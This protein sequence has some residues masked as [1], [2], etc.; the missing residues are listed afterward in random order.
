MDQQ[1]GSHDQPPPEEP[2]QSVPRGSDARGEAA[3]QQAPPPGGAACLRV[4]GLPEKGTLMVDAEGR[5]QYASP[6]AARQLG[7]R[8]GQV[9]GRRLEELFPPRA[10]PGGEALQASRAELSAIFRDAPVMM[11]LVDAQGRVL[12]SNRMALRF[13]RRRGREMAGLQPGEALR[14]LHA[15]DSP[16]GCGFGLFCGACALRASIAATLRTGKSHHRAE[17]CLPIGRRSDTREHHFLVSTVRL[18]SGGRPAVLVC[19][20]DVTA[21]RET[22]MALG[23]SQRVLS[24]LMSNL[25]GMAYRCRNDQSWTMEFI[26]GGCRE[27]TGYRPGDLVANRTVAFADLIHPDD[28]VPVWRRVQ[29]ALRERQPYELLYRIVA[30]SGEEK[31]VWEKGR[32][33]FS[34]EGDLRALE[35]F[36]TDITERKRAEQEREQMRDLLLH[37]QKME[38]VGVLAAGVAHDFN[39]LLTIIHGNAQ[40]ALNTAQEQG[41][42]ADDLVKKIL[43]A[44]EAG[45]GLVRQLMVFSRK[46]PMEM[47]SVNLNKTIGE[48]FKMLGRVI[49]ED[50][51]IDAHLFPSLWTVRG[52]ETNIEQVVMNLAVNARDA[53]PQ[54]GTLTIKTENV[55]LDRE[56]CARMPEARPGKFV[57]LTVADTGAG[58]NGGTL[59]HIFE[60]FFTTK[61]QGK[62]SGLGLSV[63]YGVVRQHGGW[64]GAASQPG[65]G[66]TF[67]VYFPASFPRPEEKARERTL[68]HGLRGSGEHV[69]LI[70]DE[71]GVLEFARRALKKSGYRVTAAADAE[72]ALEAFAQRGDEFDIVLSDVVLP[73]QSG[74]E[75]VDRLLAQRPDLKVLFTSGYAD[76]RSQWPVIHRRG[77]PF[78]HKPYT[79]IGL[80]RATK[81]ALQRQAPRGEEPA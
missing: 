4:A 70:E 40:L 49:G 29:G 72:A 50:I 28:R 76:E 63:V 69:L 23:E 22:E 78:L 34:P 12:E 10:E 18:S 80:L 55:L 31:W 56:A 74:I 8:P 73:G 39:N 27:L 64:V 2:A 75:L 20:E 51:V 7:L 24:T 66:S 79:L 44:A 9:V 42:A 71:R 58:M 6:G 53:M 30:A 46:Q 38:A 57:R 54:G 17:A 47:M 37:A 36:I 25:P 67:E 1:P 68:L 45:A 52:D 61:A 11:L 65:Q 15:L 43:D 21:R 14:C 41:G 62:G 77:I 26:S 81:E 16:R 5:V 3:G 13:A 19:L 59:E 35:G 33:V 60:P 32:G 48:L